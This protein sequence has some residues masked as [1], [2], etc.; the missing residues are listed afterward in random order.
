VRS[1]AAAERSRAAQY[2]RPPGLKSLPLQNVGAVWPLAFHAATRSAHFD[3]VSAYDFI[4]HMPRVLAAADFAV[5]RYGDI[6]GML[7]PQPQAPQR[8]ASNRR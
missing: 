7:Q 6:D 5:P 3:S 4:E 1:A 2:R 8:L